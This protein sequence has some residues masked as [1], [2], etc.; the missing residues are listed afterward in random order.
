MK[1]SNSTKTAFTTVKPNLR[2]KTANP[3]SSSLRPDKPSRPNQKIQISFKEKAS[4][5]KSVPKASNES[6]N[7]PEP[8]KIT[9][10]R[11]KCM[12]KLHTQTQI[13]KK[14]KIM[15]RFSSFNKTTSSSFRYLNTEIEKKLDKS[16][17]SINSSTNYS[18]SNTSNKKRSTSVKEKRNTSLV[19]QNQTKEILIPKKL[20]HRNT[21]EINH[22]TL[23]TDNMLNK[24]LIK[25]DVI[26]E[27]E[28]PLNFKD[29][30]DIDTIET[31]EICLTSPSNN[32]SSNEIPRMSNKEQLRSSFV[33]NKKIG[34]ESLNCNKKNQ[35]MLSTI[36]E[37]DI[38]IKRTPMNLKNTLTPKNTNMSNTFSHPQ[39]K[40]EIKNKE[41][42]F[43]GK[44]KDYIIK[45]E[46]GKGS[47]AVVRQGYHRPTQMKVALKIYD[48]I[49]LFDVQKKNSV[50]REIDILKTLH[51]ENILKLYEVIDMPKYI[52]VITELICGPSLLDL[53]KNAETHR[54]DEI[55]CKKIFH[56]IVCGINYCHIKNISHRDIKL[57]NVLVTEEEKKVKIIDFGFGVKSK[58]NISQKFFC[59]TPSYMPPE[60]VLKKNYIAQYADV[61]S[62]GVLLYTMLCGAF[63]FRATSEEE[64]YQKIIK[65]KYDFPE[66]MSE[67][68][69]KL[70]GKILKVKPNER[71]STEEILLDE[72]FDII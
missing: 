26:K 40:K 24:Y 34:R 37:T 43:T 1:K 21:T 62:L 15:H 14:E 44:I 12:K 25:T 53:L 68:A 61:W 65:G 23:H 5:N 50:N 9:V 2:I 54:I 47:Y 51:H 29:D 55:E 20:F 16:N 45:K 60:I 36:N 17:N 22:S 31:A 33:S 6:I 8:K 58:K 3:L 30:I 69:K 39:T 41:P 42:L 4:L 19:K 18:N 13:P 10:N 59:G 67:T 49:S 63:P 70:I 27:L 56:Q 38:K 32:K 66:H 71:P 46:I 35:K 7:N 57:E 52:Y 72:W 11:Q 64:L 48:K 28:E